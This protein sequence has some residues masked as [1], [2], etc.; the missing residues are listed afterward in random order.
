MSEIYTTINFTSELRNVSM[1]EVGA[2]SAAGM[3]DML[4]YQPA[5]CQPQAQ[6]R[7]T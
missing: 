6:C 5:C 4:W 1:T 3:V 7:L 2:L